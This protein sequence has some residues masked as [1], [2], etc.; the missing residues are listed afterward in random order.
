MVDAVG[1]LDGEYEGPESD[2]SGKVGKAVRF[3][4]S[5][6]NQ[7]VIV[8][9]EPSLTLPTAVSISVWIK[10]AIELNGSSGTRTIARTESY[11]LQYAGSGG[12]N[13]QFSIKPLS[14]GATN[15]L[16]PITFSAGVWKHIVAT[17]DV[18]NG[19]TMRLY[20]DGVEVGTLAG[21]GSIDVTPGALFVGQSGNFATAS[22][23]IGSIDELSLFNQSLA[24]SDVTAL[25]AA[26]NASQTVT[27]CAA[28]PKPLAHFAMDDTTNPTVTD[29]VG[30]SHG[31]NQSGSVSSSGKV[32]SALTFVDIGDH[33]SVAN[34]PTLN[35]TA[36][37]TIALWIRPTDVLS[38]LD[39][40]GHPFFDKEQSGT[41]Y[42]LTAGV[43]QDF[44]THIGGTVVSKPGVTF[45]AGSWHHLAAT[46]DGS[47][48]RFFID[49]TLAAEKGKT[50]PLAPYTGGATIGGSGGALSGHFLGAVDEVVLYDVALTDAQMTELFSLGNAGVPLH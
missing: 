31:I 13:L 16:V 28:C 35:P 4:L 22:P 45:A 46:W 5:G 40:A 34:T 38:G 21:P 41:G 32:S 3:N 17:Y 2:A 44:R 25:Y 49:G 50:T 15:L 43:G 14:G 19:N 23:F 33:V 1:D 7:H 18:S 37:L 30:A 26:G 39:S 48:V 47:M 12:G 36:A 20:V 9:N 24:L 29:V 42:I 8:E 10:P 27:A 6:T 11:F